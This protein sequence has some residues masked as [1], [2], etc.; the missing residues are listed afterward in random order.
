MM[1]PV[2]I[3]VVLLVVGTGFSLGA[4][5]VVIRWAHRWKKQ[6][7]IPDELQRE[8]RQLSRDMVVVRGQIKYIE[9]R[10]NGKGW[11]RGE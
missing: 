5:V 3:Q 10:L 4:H 6:Q 2:F 8:I 1:N 9:G 11:L 7:S